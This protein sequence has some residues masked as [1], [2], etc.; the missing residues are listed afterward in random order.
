MKLN[1]IQRKIASVIDHTALKANTTMTDIERLCREAKDFSFASVCILPFYV[2]YAK[3]MLQGSNVNICTVIGFPLG[4]SYPDIKLASAKTALQDGAEE[5]DMVMNISAFLNR[6]YAFVQEEIELV[7]HIARL[8]D[9]IVKVI[10]ETCYLKEEQKIKSCE[11]ICAANADFVKT[12]TGF[13]EGGATVED[14][15]LLKK[16]LGDKAKV[17]ASGGVRTAAFALE[18]INA[19]ADRLGASASVGIIKDAG[20]ML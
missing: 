20:K 13:S 7:V 12:S 10:I 15:L 5:L 4:G 8:K 14:V 19:G 1:D 16:N 3:K 2:P 17:K 6:D 18:L 11:I 9:A